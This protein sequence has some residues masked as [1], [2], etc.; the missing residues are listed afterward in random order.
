[1]R[2]VQL[3]IGSRVHY[4]SHGS[5]VLPDGSQ[6]HAPKCRPAIAVEPIAGEVWTFQVINPSGIHFDECRHDETRWPDAPPGTG[7]TWHWPCD[8]DPA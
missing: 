1:M 7:G 4:R 3:T 6:V 5:P 2:N 8:G